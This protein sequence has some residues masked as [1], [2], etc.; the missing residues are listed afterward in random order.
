MYDIYL[1]ALCYYICC[2]LWRIYEMHPAL[3]LKFGCDTFLD[4]LVHAVKFFEDVCTKQKVQLKTSKNKLISS[5]NDHKCL[6]EKFETFANLNCELTTKIVQLEFC[7]IVTTEFV[8][9]PPPCTRGN[10]ARGISIRS[11]IVEMVGSVREEPEAEHHLRVE[12]AHGSLWSY[13]TEVLGPHMDYCLRRGS[14]E[15]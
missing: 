4:E 1:Y 8:S 10:Q 15:Y 11:L 9:R 3:F 13:S 6:L 12:K 5:Q 2:L 7:E 14:N